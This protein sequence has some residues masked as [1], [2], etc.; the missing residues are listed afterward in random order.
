MDCERPKLRL[1]DST[2]TKLADLEDSL[3]ITGRWWYL[4]P[5]V[6]VL[7]AIAASA[8]AQKRLPLGRQIWTRIVTDG[9]LVLETQRLI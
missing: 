6:L 3:L 8:K 7:L 2:R 5:A 9:H 4:F 1:W